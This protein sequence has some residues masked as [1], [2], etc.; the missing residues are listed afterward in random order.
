MS[1]S[2]STPVNSASAFCL[3]GCYQ[4]T[5]AKSF[6]RPGHDA[7]HVSNLIAE[8]YN[9]IQDGQGISQEMIDSSAKSLPSLALKVKFQNAMDNLLDRVAAKKPRA[10]KAEVWLDDDTTGAKIGRWIYPV[11][12]REVKGER[13]AFRRNTK[14]D[15]SGE[16]V[17]APVEVLVGL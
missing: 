7:R 6:Y 9:S 5:S 4:E 10:P 12:S 8:L 16:W 17:D 2:T 1:N 11:Q 13:V 3:C 14:R 15:G